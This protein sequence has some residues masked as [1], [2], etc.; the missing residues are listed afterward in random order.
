MAHAPRTFFEVFFISEVKGLVTQEEFVG[1]VK[2]SADLRLV[3]RIRR[4]AHQPRYLYARQCLPFAGSKH[5]LAGFGR[6]AVF[7]FFLRYMQFEQ[8]GND[9]AAAQGLTVDFL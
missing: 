4:H 1:K 9:A 2:L 7:A 5:L 6:E 8:A 3:V